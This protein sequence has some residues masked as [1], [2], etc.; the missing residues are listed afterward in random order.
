MDNNH[1]LDALR[2]ILGSYIT[3]PAGIYTV[4]DAIEEEY[5]TEAINDAQRAWAGALD[6]ACSHSWKVYHGF[7]ESYEYC[8]HC[9]N[10]RPIKE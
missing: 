1:S 7:R 4:Q 6:L 10:K 2:Y 8:E 9:D 3:L 5:N